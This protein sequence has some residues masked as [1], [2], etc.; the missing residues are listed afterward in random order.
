MQIIFGKDNADQLREKYTVLEL[1]TFDVQGKMLQAYCVVPA[2]VI[3][4]GEITQIETATKL[5]HEYVVGLKKNDYE[6]CKFLAS[7]LVGK[8]GGELDSFYE[9]TLER[10]KPA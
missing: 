1:E 6:L 9:L 3:A 2:E 8:W 5:H 10:I 4:M 7:Y